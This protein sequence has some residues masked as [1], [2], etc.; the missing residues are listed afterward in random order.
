MEFWEK[1][2]NKKNTTLRALGTLEKTMKKKITKLGVL[3]K[4]NKKK[5]MASRVQARKKKMVLGI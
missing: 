5:T 1:F 4:F 2:K 3:E